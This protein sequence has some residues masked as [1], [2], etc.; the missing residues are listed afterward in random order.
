[1]IG[2]A[3][4][5]DHR[6]C[7]G[8]VAAL[9]RRC[10]GAVAAVGGGVGAVG[11]IV[12]SAATVVDA[13]AEFVV[14][15]KLPNVVG[16]ATSYAERMVMSKIDKLTKLIPGMGKKQAPTANKKSP[17]SDKKTPTPD[18]PK[19]VGDGMKVLGSGGGPC[20]VGPYNQIKDKCSEGQQAHHI[21]PDT[22]NRTS[23]RAQGAKGIGRIPGMPSLAGGPAIC[24]TGHAATDGTQHHEAHKGDV[25]IQLAAQRT[26]NGPINTLPVSEAIP[27]AKQ[28]AI[29]A[30]PECKEQID[31]EVRK[32]YPDH[33]NDK[34]SMNGAGRPPGGDA[35]SHLKSGGTANSGGTGQTRTRKR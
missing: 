33:E 1:M 21:I 34:R 32:A 22:L 27:I 35:E 9:W 10:G 12:A 23:N 13:G 26:D 31:A 17:E 30:R 15:G 29:N 3:P 7:G 11:G 18:K 28:S 20:I 14:S 19:P 24:L 4:G 5:G 6:R 25:Q 2:A 16:I 8:A